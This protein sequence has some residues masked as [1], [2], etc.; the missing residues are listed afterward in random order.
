MKQKKDKGYVAMNRKKIESIAKISKKGSSIK[1]TDGAHKLSHELAKGI[2]KHQP[3]PKATKTAPHIVKALQSDA[4]IRIKSQSG[5]RITDRKNDKAILKKYES[6][7]RL[8]N[9]NEKYRAIQAYKG[10][11]SVSHHQPTVSNI[12][13]HI[14]EM[15][16]NTGKPGQPPK[17]KNLAK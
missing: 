11:E 14:G 3:G 9:S 8:N 4:N 12:T 5:N 10:G 13:S 15:R 2:L 7:E 17:I 16:V 1:K 6:S